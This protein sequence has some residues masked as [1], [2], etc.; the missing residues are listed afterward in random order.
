MPADITTIKITKKTKERIEHIRSYRRES[1]DEILQKMLEVL[2]V[3]RADPEK[4]RAELIIID[5]ERKRNLKH[6]SDKSFTQEKIL[7]N[8]KTINLISAEKQKDKKR[9]SKLQK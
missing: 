8:G 1:Y 2:N 7:Q 5:K 3:C 4:A 6:I 9:F